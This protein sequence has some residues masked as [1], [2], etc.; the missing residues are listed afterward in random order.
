MRLWRL[1]VLGLWGAALGL[2]GVAAAQ[3][4]PPAQAPPPPSASAPAPQASG[5]APVPEADLAT[6]RRH[7]EN[8]IKLYRDQNFAGALAEFE[9]AYRIKAGAGSLQN[10]ALC[11]KALFRYAEAAR[12][13]ETLLERHGAELSEEEKGKVR[14]T[15]A[16]L[17][18]L[19]GTLRVMVTP[20]HARV[21]LDGRLVESS[22]LASLRLDVGEHTIVAEAP[23][24][25]SET[26]VVRVA[27]GHEETLDVA[28][29]ARSG[30]VSVLTNDPQAAIAIDS[31]AVAFHRWSGPV[32]P[33]RHYVQVY[34]AGFAT[35]ERVINVEVGKTAE[36][37]AAVGPP[38]GADEEE[39][40][41]GEGQKATEKPA[42]RG[43]YGLIAFSGIGLDDAPQGVDIEGA[44]E[45]AGASFGARAGYRIWTP[46]AAELLLEGGRHQ[47]KDAC[48]FVEGGQACDEVDPK[49]VDFTLESF[50]VGGNLRIM[51]AGESV[52]FTSTIGVGA[53]RHRLEIDDGLTTKTSKGTD[54]YFLVELGLQLNFGHI[55][56]EADVVAYI[57]GTSSI[58]DNANKPSF[59]ENSGLRML[60]IGLRGGW[61][62]WKPTSAPSKP[63]QPPNKQTSSSK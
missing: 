63:E 15:I 18:S 3:P 40:K 20:A 62:E 43:W 54:P 28:L 57:D 45:T 24:Y 46:V 35:F 9:A 32:A 29:R 25:A 7:F 37:Q 47:V 52:R 39:A 33:G 10:V 22:E 6:A 59:G 4:A 1:Q 8:G 38:V 60:G 31:K 41:A 5:A 53:V 61:S 34:K 21:T 30:F 16:E 44:R 58:V 14:A 27:G 19:V 2:V 23:G 17:E 13:L 36:I 55:L 51:S 26:E 11:L 42:L 49:L 56:A 48:S 50:R 12:T